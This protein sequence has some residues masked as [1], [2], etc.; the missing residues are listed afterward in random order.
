[1]EKPVKT[2]SVRSKKLRKKPGPKPKRPAKLDRSD[3][4][5][6]ANIGSRGGKNTLANL[7]VEHFRQIAVLSH[8]VRREN[9]A[10]AARLLEEATRKARRGK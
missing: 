7:G 4:D 1:M 3:E 2:S 6:F 8:Q 10:E 9:K 5:F